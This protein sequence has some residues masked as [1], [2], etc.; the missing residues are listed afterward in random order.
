MNRTSCMLPGLI[1]IIIALTFA[2][3]PVGS[4]APCGNIGDPML[5]NPGPF[6]KQGGLSLIT[7]LLYESQTN[8]LPEQITRFAWT[9]PDTQP[10]EE[11]HYPQTRWS[12][13]TLETLGV[14]LGVPFKDKAVFYAVAGK[15][16][17]SVDLHYEDWTVGR[18]FESDNSFSGSDTFY[19]AGADVVIQRG[20]FHEIPLTL[21]MDISYR[22][23]SVEED[24]IAAEG[25]AYSAEFDEV[26]LAVSLSAD[27]KRFSPYMGV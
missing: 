26:Q 21:G 9:D 7:S 10:L 19:G 17:M 15:S 24:R 20:I 18:G 27:M 12:K 8:R 14:K 3:P 4:A 16:D 1:I 22:H 25:L 2:L 5:W 13:N 6:Q 23:Y 11:R